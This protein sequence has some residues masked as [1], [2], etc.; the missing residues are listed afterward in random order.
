M[1]GCDKPS[2][3]RWR[4]IV[5]AYAAVFGV[6]FAIGGIPG[7][8]LSIYL[9]DPRFIVGWLYF[10]VG[11]LL[12]ILGAT[13]LFAVTIWPLLLVL[14]AIFGGTGNITGP[15]DPDGPGVIV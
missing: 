2:T 13:A 15:V 4:Q 6:V 14:A 5:G 8:L 11:F 12:L 9:S 3:G 7:G 1:A 10:S